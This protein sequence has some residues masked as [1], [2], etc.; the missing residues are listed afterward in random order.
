MEMSLIIVL[1]LQIVKLSIDDQIRV[2][3]KCSIWDVVIS[4][5]FKCVKNTAS[6]SPYHSARTLVAVPYLQVLTPVLL[7][8]HT[9]YNL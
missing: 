8:Y 2:L 9:F 7:V 5:G 4:I 3:E 6:E 1:K